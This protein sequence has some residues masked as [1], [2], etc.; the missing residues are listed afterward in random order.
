MHA[1]T[2]PAAAGDPGSVRAL[3]RHQRRP[4]PGLAPRP[5]PEPLLAYSRRGRIAH[6]QFRDFVVP[7]RPL[8]GRWRRGRG[9]IARRPAGRTKRG[10]SGR[11]DR[12]SQAP[13][14]GRAVQQE[15]R[16][17]RS[18]REPVDRSSL[19]RA[20][21][22]YLPARP[23][24]PRHLRRPPPRRP[25]PG[26][27][28][29][30]PTAP[31][32]TGSTAYPPPGPSAGPTY[33]LSRTP[34]A[35]CPAATGLA[36]HRP[37]AHRPDPLTHRLIRRPWAADQGPGPPR[38]ALEI[39][40]SRPGRAVRAVRHG[41]VRRSGVGPQAGGNQRIGRPW[42]VPTG[43]TYRPARLTPDIFDAHLPA[44]PPPARMPTDLRPHYPP[45]RLPT[46]PAHL[47]ARLANCPA[48][49]GS[50][51]IGPMPTGPTR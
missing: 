27:D 45:A 35:A 30:R 39:G 40:G 37:D 2:A 17:A 4:T 38:Q 33:L 46:S 6:R 47:R 36:A 34:P 1:K 13:G 22:T 48:P 41:A 5:L 9:P 26:P 7:A 21:R 42:A 31:P 8:H 25:T 3:V 50:P 11:G 49:P 15:R 29:Y 18:G 51:P 19:D 44:G 14:P 28:A 16:G 20:Y 24:H 32:P 43:P 12:S 10:S 23:A